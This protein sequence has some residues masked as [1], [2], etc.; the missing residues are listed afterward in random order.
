MKQIMNRAA[1]FSIAL[2]A[3]GKLSARE[4][5]DFDKA[6][7]KRNNG[8]YR[9]MVAGCKQPTAQ[10]DL[11]I[12]NIRTT[13]MNGGDMWWNLVSAKYEIPKVTDPNGVRK[14]SIFAGSIWIGGLDAGSNLK[15]AAMT[16]RQGGVDYFSGPLDTTTTPNPTID[17]SQCEAYDRIYKVTRKEISSYLEDFADNGQIDNAVP[18][19]FIDWPGNGDPRYNQSKHLAPY[20]EI[21]GVEG[22]DPANGDYPD[23]PGDMALWFVYN[24]KGNIH[25]E[26]QGVPIGVELRTTA[27]A[28]ATND[29]INN[30][31]FYNTTIINRGEPIQQTYFGQWADPDLGNYSD[32]YVG[33]DTTRSLGFCY[34]ADD[35]DEG[36]LGYGLNPPTVGI[37]FFKGPKDS[38]GN[39]LKLSNFVYY[40]NG[41]TPATSDP[42]RAIDFYNYMRGKWK[43]GTCFTVGGSGYGG[44]KCTP[45][46]FP[47]DPL[48]QGEWHE[49]SAGNSGG[50]RRFMQSAGPFDMATG[51]INDLTIGVVWAKSSVGG[52]TG[53]LTLLKLA[54][55]KAQLLYNNNFKLIDGPDAPDMSIKEYKNQLVLTLENTLTPKVES[56]IKDVRNPFYRRDSLGTNSGDS[57][58]TY[59]FQGYQIYQLKDASIGTT[60]T[61]L[62]NT[63]KARL[64]YQVDLRDNIKQLVNRVFDGTVSQYVPVSKVLGADE[65]L[66]HTFEVHEDL[67]ATGSDK[68][69]VNFKSYYYVVK[70]YANIFNDPKNTN[71]EQYLGGRNN[72]KI[73]K[74]VPHNSLP[75]DGGSLIKTLYGNG[76]RIKQLSGSGNGGNYLELTDESVDMILKDGKMAEP[77]YANGKGPI[78][79]KIIDPLKVGN[80]KF[81]VF[82]DTTLNTPVKGVRDSLFGHYTRWRLINKS[83]N[84]TIYSDST[85]SVY[86]EQVIAKWGLSVSIVQANAPGSYKDEFDKS[87][88]VVGSQIKW[89]DNSKKW[90]DGVV[91]GEGEE[92]I[93]WIRAGNSGKQ[94]NFGGGDADVDYKFKYDFGVNFSGNGVEYSSLDPFEN[95]E[96]ICDRKVGPYRLCSRA[97]REGARATFGPGFD[98][99]PTSKYAP[100]T[101][102]KYENRLEDLASVDL[103]YTSDR[104]KW[105]RCIVIETGEDE[106]LNDG[107]R[108]KFSLRAHKSVDKDGKTIDQGGINDPTNPD[109]ANYIG[110]EGMGWFPGYAI[111]LETGDR[112]NIIFGEDSW[113]KGDNGD[114][115]RWNPT[116]RIGSGGGPVFG[117]KHFVYVCGSIAYQNVSYIGPAYDMGKSYYDILSANTS[118]KGTEVRR[119][120]SQIMWVTMPYLSEGFKLDP[121]NIVPEGANVRFS[122][123]VS[124]PY[125]KFNSRQENVG[126][127]HYEFNT[128][129]IGVVKSAEHGRTAVTDLIN[130]VPN[131]YYAGSL[132]E[133]GQLDTRVKIT[134]LPPQCIISIYTLNGTLVRRIRKN[135]ALTYLDWD[136]KNQAQVP[137]ASGM[138]L[139]HI[140]AGELG[141]RTLKWFG[142]MRPI[143]LDT[144]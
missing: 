110:A 104:T 109:A 28:F 80:N 9:T 50:D 118:Q 91:D 137:V 123:R 77:I 85:I 95:Y 127:P 68:K 140:D 1:I 122:M 11:D 23:V 59:K 22:Y 87:N 13:I 92:Y 93:N 101:A 45:F 52:A 106:N 56:Y 44:S 131:P 7:P 62:E 108:K 16:Y 94:D 113:Q 129:D 67:F 36:I 10:V 40:N 88:G 133:N 74:A 76:P 20:V 32:D 86:N 130:I 19:S 21:D 119:V 64:L 82:L 69:L 38:K 25:S 54:D 111:N 17:P 14:H 48:N 75:V 6:A 39:E 144:F 126:L 143:D 125:S 105:T 103:V 55:D 61:D 34:N 53:S 72:I 35:N 100:N 78:A 128:E 60:E 66:R 63:E 124:K 30:M 112:L 31:T 24:D 79:I 3:F 84:D 107:N 12:N 43:D 15:V 33:C 98:E 116:S 97:L 70:S 47:G 57:L 42:R 71:T 132:Y 73:Y 81:E 102:V 27:F 117:G 49:K 58:Y 121:K 135:D 65:G 96:K 90:L 114:D 18:K 4:I 141:E 134:N 142:I 26:S 139:I 46:C 29:E 51:A 120:T 5:V 138:Y 99:S 37:D 89:Q 8:H 83:T 115:L 41:G 2:L 136:I